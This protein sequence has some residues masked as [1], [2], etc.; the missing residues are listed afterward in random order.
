MS[1]SSVKLLFRET[2]QILDESVVSY[3]HISHLSQKI[4]S[5][6]RE[7]VGT[8]EVL[9]G[10]NSIHAV[11]LFGSASNSQNTKISDVDLMVLV[12]DSVNDRRIKETK[13][14]LTG[15]VIKHRY[16][17][18]SNTWHARILHIIEKST[19]MFCSIFLAK[20]SNW[21][22]NNF[23]K[24]FST[25]PVLTYLLAPHKIVLDSMK[26]GTTVLYQAQNE[27]IHLQPLEKTYSKSQLI[28]SLILNLIMSL[29]T[30]FLLP[31]NKK[32]SKYMLEAIKWS[33]R[34]CDF[35]ENKEINSLSKILKKIQKHGIE[36][37]FI[38]RFL[39][40]RKTL[41]RDL[42]FCLKV[43]LNIIKIHL[44]ALNL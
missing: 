29:G 27:D 34:S 4:Q 6:I 40:L 43:P 15:I 13:P 28:K 16:R 30:L 10:R 37:D 35:Y 22:R 17:N 44:I 12:N 36:V 5:Y 19:G 38:Q 11:M 8:T 33:I 7:I 9:L 41:K 42:I 31:L 26:R 18:Y 1:K 21:D 23:S 14:F 2:F 25:N 32:N 39:E 24:I 20:I 3:L